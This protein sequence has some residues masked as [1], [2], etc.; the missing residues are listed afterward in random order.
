MV[1]IDGHFLGQRVTVKAKGRLFIGVEKNLVEPVFIG[2]ALHEVSDYAIDSGILGIVGEGARVGHHARQKR[3]RHRHVNITGESQIN[4]DIVEQQTGRRDL[5]PAH[6]YVGKRIGIEMMVNHDLQR[7]RARQRFF[8]TV[9]TTRLV[10]VKTEDNPGRRQ[11]T[12]H[13]LGMLRRNRY[14]AYTGQKTETLRRHIGSYN[15][16]VAVPHGAENA[17]KRQRRADGVGTCL[18]HVALQRP[19]CQLH[20]KRAKG[21]SL[22]PGRIICPDEF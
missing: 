6:N 7:L 10:E 1:G 13:G 9:D 19:D 17:K 11:Q 18:R 12:A 2:A 20:L 8:K 4:Q 15:P 22:R 5:G 14:F 16:D 21:T 3:L